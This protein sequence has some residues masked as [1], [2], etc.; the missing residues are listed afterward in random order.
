MEDELT[1]LDGIFF[2]VGPV[3]LQM[4]IDCL[5]NLEGTPTV[6]GGGGKTALVHYTP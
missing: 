3:V 6:V 1:G 2:G 5:R 4:E